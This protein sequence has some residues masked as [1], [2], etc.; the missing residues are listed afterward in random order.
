M[1]VNFI[2]FN[3]TFPKDC[4]PLSRID[5]LVNSTMEYEIFCFLH[6]FKGYHQIEM[7]EKD[8]EKMAFYLDRGVYC[9][10]IMPFRLKN[11][12]AIYQ[13]LINRIFHNQIG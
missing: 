10:T 5:V 8:Q 13:R 6:A 12:G 11:A 9:Y 7:S 2:D 4:Y 3:K 1:C